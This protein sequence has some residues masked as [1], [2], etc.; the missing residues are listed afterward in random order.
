MRNV[1]KNDIYLGLSKTCWA[2]YVL[3]DQAL[4]GGGML[5]NE[6]SSSYDCFDKAELP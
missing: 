3:V 6:C 2:R 5:S 4:R 1:A